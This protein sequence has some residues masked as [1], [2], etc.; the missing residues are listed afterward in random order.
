MKDLQ[1]DK[2]VTYLG[3]P[4]EITGV[5]DKNGRE[6]V[7]VAYDKGYGRTKSIYDFS[8]KWRC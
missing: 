4:G 6:F 3:H 7:S 1:K 5:Y 2:K 8:F